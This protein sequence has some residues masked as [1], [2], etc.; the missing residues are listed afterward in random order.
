MISRRLVSLTAVLL[1]AGSIP[2]ARA[3]DSAEPT[4]SSQSA[5]LGDAAR[6]ARAQKKDSGKPAKV[7]TNDNVGDLK[8]TI[9]VIGNAPAPASATD[10]TSE[11][12]DDK[13][14]A[15]GADVKDAKKAQA[16]DESGWR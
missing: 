11:K 8:G 9:S 5:S 2:L 12:T 13:K 7:F 14:P 4:S 16:Q 6:K 10:I 15:N 1:V 3:Q